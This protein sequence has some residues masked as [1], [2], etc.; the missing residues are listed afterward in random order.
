MATGDFIQIDK[1]DLG[2]SRI[3]VVRGS[4]AR[5]ATKAS[6]LM[7]AKNNRDWFTCYASMPKDVSSTS[8]IK[9]SEF[10]QASVITGCAKTYPESPTTY[11]TADNGS[12]EI[13]LYCQS[14][15][16]D[17]DGKK[18][19]QFFVPGDSGWVSCIEDTNNPNPDLRSR[20]KNCL[21]H[22]T[23]TVY[24]RDGLST[25]TTQI[26]K[27]VVVGYGGGQNIYANIQ[28]S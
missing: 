24:A 1:T 6:S 16:T 8:E 27:A 20:S 5:Q 12:V 4:N 2:A 3:N 10:R 15:V 7:S 18:N 9:W 25:G 28:Q 21:G 17:K 23:Y 13:Y 26:S 11:G 19:Y 14:V 22:G